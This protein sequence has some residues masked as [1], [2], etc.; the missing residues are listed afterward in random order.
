MVL[1]KK[2]LISQYFMPK[3]KKIKFFYGFSVLRVPT[4]S[5]MSNLYLYIAQPRT[6]VTRIFFSM[7]NYASALI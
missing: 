3:V 5:D 1:S 6:S 4:C 2:K 7:V